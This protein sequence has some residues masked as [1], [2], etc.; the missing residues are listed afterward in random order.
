MGN[1]SFDVVDE[2]HCD[3]FAE[4]AVPRSG[5]H[6]VAERSFDRRKHCFRECS[7]TVCIRIDPRVVRVIDGAELSML[8]Q[9]SYVLF[10]EFI[11]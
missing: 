9:R 2:T 3:D 11:T 4:F 10:P 8:D 1:G 5:T 6:G 7:L